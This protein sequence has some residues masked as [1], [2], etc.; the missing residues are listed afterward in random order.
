MKVWMYECMDIWMKDEWMNKGINEWMSEG[1]N[2][3]LR[4]FM[5][6]YI[7]SG[8][9][10]I[11]QV[12]GLINDVMKEWMNSQMYERMYTWMKEWKSPSGSMEHNRK[13]V[14]ERVIQVNETQSELNQMN[15]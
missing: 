6:H 14:K 3:W 7:K 11:I 2:E 4:N 1:M 12:C 10:I 13:S 8:I 9:K 5:E 15:E